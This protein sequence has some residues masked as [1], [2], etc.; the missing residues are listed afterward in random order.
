MLPITF[1]RKDLPRVPAHWQTFQTRNSPLSGKS[2]RVAANPPNAM[3]NYLYAILES[4][5]RLAVTAL[6][7]DPGLGFL[8]S[9][10][11]N[12]DSLALDIMEPLRPQVDVFVLDWIMREPIKR[13]WFFEQHDGSCRLMGSFASR[14]SE[15]AETWRHSIAPVAEL[16]AH[17]L[18]QSTSKNSVRPRRPGTPLTQQNLREANDRAPL[19]PSKSG[20]RPVSLCRIC[21][22]P[23]APGR[24][25]CAACGVIYSTENV[26]RA[27]KKGCEKSH[28]P[29]AE[30]RR[31]ESARRSAI[32]Q[33]HWDPSTLPA[34]LTQETY[35]NTI[36]PL[37]ARVPVTVIVSAVGVS[38]STAAEFRRGRR[39]PHP[40]HWLALAELAGFSA[41]RGKG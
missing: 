33:W 8:H 21:G 38:R 10:S 31:A 27:A 36:H 20:L 4:E 3:L 32:A 17:S 11:A 13:E 18:W 39:I 7:L 28:S 29:E 2:A 12:R 5:A 1:P 19:P 34:W 16:V 25:Y 22:V 9:D 15:T 26:V 30:N 24:S 35:V 37:L 41:D 6:G 40:R 14:L 23:V